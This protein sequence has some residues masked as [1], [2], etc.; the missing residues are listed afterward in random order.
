[1]NH[2]KIN[3]DESSIYQ[4]VSF[5]WDFVS[6]LMVFP[7]CLDAEYWPFMQGSNVQQTQIVLKLLC[8]LPGASTDICVY[9]YICIYIYIYKHFGRR[10]SHIRITHCALLAKVQYATTDGK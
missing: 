4:V 1:M 3:I 10:I 7:E 9:I 6:C 8:M 5:I 2:L